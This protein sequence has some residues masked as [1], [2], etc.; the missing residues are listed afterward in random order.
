MMFRRIKIVFLFFLLVFPNTAL[1]SLGP[2][3]NRIVGLES[4]S[5]QLEPRFYNRFGLLQPVESSSGQYHDRESDLYYNVQRYYDPSIGRYISVDPARDS[6]DYVYAENN[7]LKYVDPTGTVVKYA[8]KLGGAVVAEGTVGEF[9]GLTGSA[10]ISG[11]SDID[12]LLQGLKNE[13][14]VFQAACSI[15][16]G[17]ATG[18]GLMALSKFLFVTP[19]GRYIDAAQSV[20]IGIFSA[21]GGVKAGQTVGDFCAMADRKLGL[22]P[23]YDS[24]EQLGRELREK[25]LI[26]EAKRFSQSFDNLSTGFDTINQKTRNYCLNRRNRSEPICR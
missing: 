6:H 23:S 5:S 22:V 20:G 17:A 14:G 4:Y 21:L 7:P 18:K 9:L 19:A 26:E 10:V 12:T 25:L 8:I 15:G 16:A 2:E 11:K 3:A 1:A 13:I 24:I